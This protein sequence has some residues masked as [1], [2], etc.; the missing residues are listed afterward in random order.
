MALGSLLPG[1]Y[2]RVVAKLEASTNPII[3][4]LSVFFLVTV[5]RWYVYSPTTL[6]RTAGQLAI[7]FGAAYLLHSM[8]Q[9]SKQSRLRINGASD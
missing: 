1:L 3:V 7:L 6:L 8:Y 9:K 2:V 4:V 5:F